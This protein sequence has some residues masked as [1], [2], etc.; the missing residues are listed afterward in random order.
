LFP[1]GQLVA[2]PGAIRECA[3]AEVTPLEYIRRHQV[4]D[5]GELDEED[6]CANEQALGRGSRILSAYNLPTRARLWVITEADRSVTT[7]LLPEEY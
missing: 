6:R 3:R 2:T 7:A 5:W 4:G 1:L